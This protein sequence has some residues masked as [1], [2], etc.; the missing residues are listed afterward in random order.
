MPP[1]GRDEELSAVVAEEVLRPYILPDP[2][3]KPTILMEVVMRLHWLAR[4]PLLVLCALLTSGC[5]AIAASLTEEEE[6]PELAARV[7]VNTSSRVYH[8]LGSADYGSTQAGT[9]MSEADAGAQGNRPARGQICGPP[10]VWVN[11][12]SAIYHC[13]GT[14]NYGTTAEGV[15]ATQ[16]EAQK[17]GARPAAGKPCFP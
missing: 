17:A 9:Y 3:A 4:R 6:A 12:R 15:Y 14:A 16:D 7:W 10:R 1:A 11:V 5:A 2:S 8:C 13:P